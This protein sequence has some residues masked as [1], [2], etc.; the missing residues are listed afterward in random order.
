[1]GFISRWFAKRGNVGG[2]ARSVG[3][4]WQRLKNEDPKKKPKD[5]AEACIVLR[6]A[7]RGE[8]FLAKKVSTYVK[9]NGVSPFNLAW[10]ILSI[11]T[12]IYGEKDGMHLESDTY[13]EWMWV[14]K[15]EL[16]KFDLE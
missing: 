6:Y 10:G 3:L 4:L 2:V 13:N 1:M 9:K 11:E 7:A 8:D 5:I 15:D 16:A 14:M 12:D